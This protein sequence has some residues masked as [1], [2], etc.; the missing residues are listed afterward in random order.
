MTTEL[1]AGIDDRTTDDM[2]PEQREAD[3]TVTLGK[4]WRCE[5]TTDGTLRF[6]G[7]K[8]GTVIEIGADDHDEWLTLIREAAMAGAAWA[9]LE[10]HREREE[11]SRASHPAGDGLDL[12]RCFAECEAPGVLGVIR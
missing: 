5:A 2:P 12:F 7:R 6:V 3:L 10:A 9:D 4:A 1:D 8:N 11:R